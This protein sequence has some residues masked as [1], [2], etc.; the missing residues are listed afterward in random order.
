[1]PV[2]RQISYLCLRSA[3]FKKIK[4]QRLPKQTK[5]P[6]ATAMKTSSKILAIVIPT[7]TIAAT[8]STIADYVIITHSRQRQIETQMSSLTELT[9]G[10]ITS[11]LTAIRKELTW[12]SQQPEVQTGDWSVMGGYLAAKDREMSDNFMNLMFIEPSGDYY[13]AGQGKINGHNLSDRQYFEEV[14]TEGYGFAMTS[15]DY[16]KYT[17]KMKYTLAVPVN[18]ADGNIKGCIAA[19]ISVDILSDMVSILSASSEKFAWVIDESCNVIGAADKRLILKY[20][21][22]QEARGEGM[23]EMAESVGKHSY[24]TGYM[25]IDDG[26]RYFV[27]CHPIGGTPGW[28]L[29]CGVSESSI[30]ETAN[31]MLLRSA[32]ILIATIIALAILLKLTLSRTLKEKRKPEEV[33]EDEEQETLIE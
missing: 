31:N 10:Q 20:N 30:T 16:S 11:S 24:S 1:M 26:K 33:A 28:S 21:L 29:L 8:I 27:A 3:V 9:A 18:G 12:I 5:S 2:A 22:L 6:H 13:F 32:A 14:M 4:A 23:D 15:P 7:I 17:G 19:N 25:D